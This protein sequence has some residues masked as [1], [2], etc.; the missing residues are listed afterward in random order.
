MNARRYRF[1]GFTLIELMI[2]MT[3]G[4]LTVMAAL[5]VLARVQDLYRI[6]E[7][8]ARLQEQGRTAFATL[9]PDIEM[10]GFYGF[11]QAAETIRFIR[12]GSRSNVV[13]SAL[14]LRQFPIRATDALPAAVAGL[15]AGAHGCG[16][17]FAVDVSMPVQASNNV[18]A[19]GRSPGAS[20]G[21]Y[22]ARAQARADTLTLRRVATH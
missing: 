5:E 21:P 22:Q 16:V 10:A 13:A 4:T 14:A 9:E 19:L 8:V 7:R 11:T 15:P 18:F 6:N 2:A 3:I 20:C 12:D 17:N 1:A